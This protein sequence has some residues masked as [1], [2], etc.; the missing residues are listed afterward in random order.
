VA[1][2]RP[3]ERSL[4]SGEVAI[5][6][7]RDLG[8]REAAAVDQGGVAQRV[9]DDRVATPD[10]RRDDAQVRLVAGREDERRLGAEE[11]GELLLQRLV[12]GEV[13][14]DEARARRRAALVAGRAR[15]GLHHFRVVREVR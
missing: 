11:R 1:G 7:H 15:R 8:A 13:P 6:Y 5:G 12:G 10:E 14:V 9:G 4:E 2:G 3:V